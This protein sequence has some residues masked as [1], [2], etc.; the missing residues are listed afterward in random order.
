MV[1][2]QVPRLVGDPVWDICAPAAVLL[3]TAGNTVRARASQRTWTPGKDTGSRIGGQ[4]D[5]VIA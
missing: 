1:W 3:P 5:R 2:G 4:K